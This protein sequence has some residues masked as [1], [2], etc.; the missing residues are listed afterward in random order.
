MVKAAELT[1]DKKD[2]TVKK[3]NG[4]KKKPIVTGVWPCKI[5]GCNKQFARE[6]DLKRHQR[7][8]KMHSLPG[9]ACPQCDATFTRT[10]ALRRHQKSRHNGVIIEPTDQE[11]R[12]G[13]DEDTRSSGSNSRSPSAQP[14]SKGKERATESPSTS[15][16]ASTN[17]PSSYY[18]Q[19][20]A[21]GAPYPP[22]R[23]VMNPHYAQI[24]LPTSATRLNTATNWGYPHPWPDGMPYGTGAVP[25][26]PNTLY[27]ASHYRTHVS[28]TRQPT[29]PTKTQSDLSDDSPPASAT[30]PP[31]S[32]TKEGNNVPTIPPIATPGSVI[33]PSLHNS[34]S[35]SASPTGYVAPPIS[36]EVTQ[37]GLKA[38]LDSVKREAAAAAASEAHAS[39]PKSSSTGISQVRDPPPSYTT[40]M[41][42]KQGALPPP[43]R[44]TTNGSHGPDADEEE[45]SATDQLSVVEETSRGV[46]PYAASTTLER[47][48]PMEHI[49]T[50]DGEPMLNPAELLT[51]ES[52]ASPPPS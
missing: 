47:P 6:A 35:Q 38:V 41:E 37:A 18:R 9:F 51:S 27:Y 39:S 34:Q 19:H 16:T 1:D 13:G 50:E 3:K 20:T 2:S 10:D 14:S 5:N 25:Y 21:A 11:Q 36:T 48:E 22:P 30:E 12:S 17:G 7:T 29:S 4:T 45:R 15:A 42:E 40:A 8:T 28:G 33:D 52:L 23:P 43:A 49:M 31:H 46:D 26:H 44:T 24:A 32:S